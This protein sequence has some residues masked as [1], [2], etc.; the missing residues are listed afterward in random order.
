[1]KKESLLR[2][3]S[4]RSKGL[5]IRA[6]SSHEEPNW[7]KIAEK[8]PGWVSRIL[9]PEIRSIVKEGV[10]EQMKIVGAKIASLDAKIASLDIKIASLDAKIEKRTKALE[11]EISSLRNELDVKI[12]SLRNEMNARFDSIE[13]RLPLIER[14]VQIEARIERLER[15]VGIQK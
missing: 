6:R 12:T 8:A 10:S 5:S 13:K 14:L 4:A 2:F 1:M 11:K 9:L 7:L 15:Q 3:F